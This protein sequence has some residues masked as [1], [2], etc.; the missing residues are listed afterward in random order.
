[1]CHDLTPSLQ[2]TI[3]LKIEKPLE[4]FQRLCIAYCP[5]PCAGITQF[6]FVRSVAG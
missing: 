2:E 5:P 1:M 3:E 6:R 4:G